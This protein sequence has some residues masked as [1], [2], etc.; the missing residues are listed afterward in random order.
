MLEILAT[1]ILIVLAL[2]LAA[3]AFLA[4]IHLFDI[5]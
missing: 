5:H 2:Y 3:M 4:F 1:V